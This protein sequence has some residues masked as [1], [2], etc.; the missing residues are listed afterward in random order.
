M[1][2]FLML[3]SLI[4]ALHAAPAHALM[5]FGDI[6]GVPKMSYHNLEFR[7]NYV[8]IT[9]RNSNDFPVR[10]YATVAFASIMDEILGEIF[11]D[12]TIIPSG[13]E[14]SK[15]AIVIRGDPKKVHNASKIFW[16]IH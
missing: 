8:E 14:A 6:P 3:A 10:F 13:G 15:K 7:G 5:S 16:V 11:L 12:F 9:I 2:R 1:K 4:L